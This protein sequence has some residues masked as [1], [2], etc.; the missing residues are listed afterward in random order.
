MSVT[1]ERF[2]PV[3]RWSSSSLGTVTAIASQTFETEAEARRKPRGPFVASN[4]QIIEVIRVTHTQRAEG[5]VMRFGARG[6]LISK[7]KERE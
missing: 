5:A 3:Y 7:R 6:A 1:L 4:I 2:I